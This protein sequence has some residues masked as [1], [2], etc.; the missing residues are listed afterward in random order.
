MGISLKPI[1]AGGGGGGGLHFRDPVDSFANDAA[2]STYFTTTASDAYLQFVADRSLAVVHG[3]GTSQEFQTYIG[4]DSGYD[5]TQW[6][7][8]I[9]AVRGPIGLMGNQ[10]IWYARIFINAATAPTA[11]PAGGS[12]ADDGT[13]T[14]PTGYVDAEN[15]VA[16]ATGEDTYESI[17]KIN[18][19]TDTFPLVPTWSF[20]FEVGGTGGANAAAAAAASAVAAAASEAAAATS[21]TGAAGSA[22]SATGS[23]I[24]AEASADAAASDANLVTSYSGPVALIEDAAFE[25]NA[26]EY[27]VTSWRDYDFLQFVLRDGNATTQ[28][29]RPSSLVPTA[30]LDTVGIA[31]APFNRNAYVRVTRTDGSDVLEI[32]ISSW[33]GHPTAE[34][35]ITIN[36]IRS[37]VEPGGGTP[38]PGGINETNLAIAN[39]DAVSLDITSDTGTDATI[40]SASI[41]EAGLMSAVDKVS[42]GRKQN[43]YFL[44]GGTPNARTIEFTAPAGF[45]AAANGD[46]ITFQV[47]AAWSYTGIQGLALDIGTQFLNVNGT[48]GEVFPA[49]NAEP[50][51]YYH[52]VFG[53]LRWEIVGDGVTVEEGG[54]YGGEMLFG[55]VDPVA[56]DGRDRD[57]WINMTSNTLWKKAA[58]AWTEQYTFPSGPAPVGDHTRRAAISTDTTLAQAEYDAGTTSTTEDITIPTWALGSRYPFL[59]VPED[60][61]DITDVEQSGISEFNTWERVAG[62]SFG[63]KWWRKSN[64]VSVFNSGRTYTIVQ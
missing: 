48:D 43:H 64:A 13:I 14:P 21:A 50:G 53:G 34:D 31:E 29:A 36:G 61:D 59:G 27:T 44:T 1:G 62:V 57:T 47:P 63:H 32:S 38:G 7:N 41:T 23:A 4:D 24:S 10:G 11:A 46:A 8:R 20:P 45:T 26:T 9:D 28:L 12:I 2:R 40:P 5:D 22:T 18:P 35:V 55:A 37:G 30:L 33:S 54:R 49:A 60:E 56:T 25:S 52:A 58:G 42:L 16:P 19:K 15:I 3:T 51:S 39:R 17:S 6:L